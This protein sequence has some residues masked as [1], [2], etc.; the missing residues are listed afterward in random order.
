MVIQVQSNDGYRDV[1]VLYEVM[2]DW[3]YELNASIMVV[4][5]VGYGGHKRK[6]RFH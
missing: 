6:L 3:P 4:C 2:K 1:K 5:Q